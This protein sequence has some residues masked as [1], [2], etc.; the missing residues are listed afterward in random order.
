MFV[1]L[2]PTQCSDDSAQDRPPAPEVGVF[3]TRP[4]SRPRGWRIQHVGCRCLSG[5]MTAATTTTGH[6]S[7][8]PAW[9]FPPTGGAGPPPSTNLGQYRVTSCDLVRRSWTSI[10][11]LLPLPPSYA[12]HAVSA[13]VGPHPLGASAQMCKAPPP[14]D[15]VGTARGVWARLSTRTRTR[16]A[17]VSARLAGGRHAWHSTLRPSRRRDH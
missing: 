13:R 5:C 3:S 14:N 10:V 8:S 11:E 6:A 2:V 16:A 4:S 12:L 17:R 15:N 7:S 1:S 9:A